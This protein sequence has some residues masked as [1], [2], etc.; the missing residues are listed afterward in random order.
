[1]AGVHIKSG[2]G[3]EN[4]NKKSEDSSATFSCDLCQK[5]FRKSHSLKKHLV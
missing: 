4:N 3:E 5:L 2:L 1:M